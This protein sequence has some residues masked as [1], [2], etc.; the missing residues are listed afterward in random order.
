MNNKQIE[1][2]KQQL[3]FTSRQ[4]E[5]LIGV[6]LGDGHLETQNNGRTYR[7]KIEHSIKQRE[8]VDW[9]Y[10]EFKDWV[11]T[12]PQLKLG[13]RGE[14][15]YQK[16]AFQTVSSPSLRFYAQ[17]FYNKRK[18]VV[19]T[20][21]AKWLTPLA[22]AVWYMDDG[23]IKSKQ[24]S[25]VLF[26]TQG[27]EQPDIV[28]LQAALLKNFGIETVLRQ[29]PDGLQIYLLSKTIPQFKQAIKNRIISSMQYKLP[30]K[31]LTILPK[32]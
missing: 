6:L 14:K 28:R 9:L 20:Q 17:Q 5:I 12:P 3:K 27:F 16:Y 31:W 32:R 25:T 7:L 26:N 23:S 24:H 1:L 15:T 19:P 21:I 8:Y 29:Q 30:N 4:R 13:V 18:K 22:L 10:A 11:L 2:R